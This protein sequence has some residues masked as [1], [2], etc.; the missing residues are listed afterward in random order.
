MNNKHL[1]LLSIILFPIFLFADTYPEVVFDNSILK[2]YYAKSKV[3]YTGDSWV[4]NV[5]KHLLVSD[6][7]FFT[8]GNSL[9]LRYLSAE[10]GSWETS[11]NY[12]RQKFNYTV[13]QSDMLN[14]RIFIESQTSSKEQLPKIFIRQQQASS[15]TLALS[16]FISKIEYN[17]W[18]HIKIPVKAFNIYDKKA[19]ILGVGFAQNMPTESYQQLFIDQIEFLP[20]KY[21]EIPLHAKAILSEAKA[22]DKAVHLHWQL[23]L[24]PSIR[25]IKIYRSTDNKNFQAISIRPI[26]M[27]SSFDIVPVIGQK[28]YYK[29]AWMDYNYKE[30]PASAVKEVE[31]SALQDNDIV[32][33]VQLAHVNYFV[34]NFD[35]NSGM[36]VPY[37]SKNKV[38]VSTKETANA[39]L[40]LIVGVNNDY[41]SRQ[42]VV[43][44]ISKIVFFLL[45][46]QH[47]N[48]IFSAY[49]DARKAIPEYKNELSIYDVQ[50]SG[51]IIEALLIAREYFDE[52]NDLEKDLR[53][54][55]S[56]IY[57]RV[58]WQNISSTDS[59]LLSKLSHV[60][61][62]S[63]NSNVLV[64]IDKSINTY[65]LAAS[66][67]KSPLPK[68]A[69]FQAL[70]SKLVNVKQD[71]MESVNPY[72]FDQ[73]I[74]HEDFLSLKFNQS[75]D[76]ILRISAIDSLKKYGTNLPFGE[77]NRSLLDF[78]RPF[79]TIRPELINDTLVNWKQS[80]NNYL[81][82]VKRRDNEL[83]VG[84]TSS[85]IWGFYQSYN[86]GSSYR[87]NPAIS[88]SSIMIDPS[89]GK[90]SIISLYK[91][92]GNILF[93]EYGFRS[94]LDLRDDDVSDE[95][96]SLNQ[97]A[98]AI[99]IENANT[100]LIWKLYEK[101]P[102]LKQA[103]AH[104]FSNKQQ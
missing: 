22:Y 51:A 70:Y 3:N 61:T 102:E 62:D 85:D 58:Q 55:I 100:G 8:P 68:D 38:V 30:S 47:N 63:L 4:E 26:H 56:E 67:M 59:L 53:A 44:R 80:L 54:R 77:L 23:P 82:F 49:Y 17:K 12:S 46:S 18:I 66:S 50:A 2:G 104:I 65:L 45:K 36:Y 20:N 95:Y 33:L 24:S 89:V 35:I 86:N 87:I 83:G 39:I 7:L 11:I 16:S 34:E 79:L 10:N 76:T 103:R 69:Y 25:Y 6:T 57:Q 96:L 31:T 88:A 91:L 81:Q 101:I 98:V 99:A 1:L 19:P 75:R 97:A 74:S 93:S 21:S 9:S 60:Q 84:T 52:N 14:L 92:Y 40:S 71:T 90:K 41:I 42:K 72:Y 43:Q 78:Y 28:Y 5:N 48:G 15:D 29:I 37:R 13:D 64:G 32:K 73:S 94:W 27:Q